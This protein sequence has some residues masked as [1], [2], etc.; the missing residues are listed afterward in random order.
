MLFYVHFITNDS[1][2][3]VMRINY[4][5]KMKNVKHLQLQCPFYQQAFSVTFI[6]PVGGGMFGRSLAET[7]KFETSR[8]RGYV[9]FIVQKCVD[10][11]RANGKHV[12]YKLIMWSAGFSC[13]L[14]KLKL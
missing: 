8:G 3:P 13:V 5:Y 1:C 7:V 14:S 2:C 4:E 9:P 6:Q 12:L 11:I 10:F